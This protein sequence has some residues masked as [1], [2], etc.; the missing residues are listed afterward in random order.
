MKSIA[1]NDHA[2]KEVKKYCQTLGITIGEFVEY[3]TTYFRNA[4]IDPS[5]SDAES[6]HKVVKELEKRIGQIVA[7]IRTHEKEK[8]D[9][10]LESLIILNRQLEDFIIQAPKEESF[11]KVL[12]NVS[13]LL[14]A[15]KKASLEQEERQAKSHQENNK[16]ILDSFNELSGAI[17]KL[18]QAQVSMKAEQSTIK[19]VIETKLSKKIF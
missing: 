2:H 18:Q 1:I 8:L 15:Q 16:V 6:P 7:Y 17:Q 3:S 9:P 19:E 11:K 5:K 12:S 14:A 10:L 4:G 13:Q